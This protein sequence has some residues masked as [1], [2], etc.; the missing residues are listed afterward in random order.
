MEEPKHFK[1]SIELVDK[2][3]IIYT[4]QNGGAKKKINTSQG[5]R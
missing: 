3:Q 4:S 2:N 1:I 5:K